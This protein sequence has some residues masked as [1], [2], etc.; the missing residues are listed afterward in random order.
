MR[1]LSIQLILAAAFVT[2]LLETRC[3]AQVSLAWDP[4]TDPSVAGYYLSWGTNSGD[5]TMTNTY[6]VPE[7]NAVISNLISNQVYFFAVAAF[8]TNGAV[9]AFSNEASCTNAPLSLNQ[10]NTNEQPPVPGSNSPPNTNISQLGIPGSNNVNN[11]NNSSPGQNSGSNSAANFWGVP[12]FL[13]LT[14]TNGLPNLNVGGTVGATLMLQAT[15][16]LLSVDSWETV[17]NFNMTNIATFAESNQQTQPQD[18]LD[19]AFVPGLQSVPIAASN[20]TSF[21]FFRVVMPYDYVILAS[22]TLT[23]QGYTPRL[24]VVN[25]PGIVCDDACYINQTSS[26][27]HYDRGNYALQLEAA[28]STIRNVATTLSTSLGVDWTSASEFTYSNGLCQVL[29]TVVETETPG[30]DPIAG[31][32]PP[33]PPMSIDF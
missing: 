16:N 7:T 28:G 15:T 20:S 6:M 29:A 10:S 14:L 9:S 1:A 31:Q 13:T 18:A 12:P 22:M 3:D 23:N 11:V 26:F 19:L 2:G 21:Q 8:S 17:T 25:M 27:I 30:N 24:I 4:S 33:S 5:Y 32:K